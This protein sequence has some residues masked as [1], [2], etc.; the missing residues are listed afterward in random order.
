MSKQDW[1]SEIACAVVALVI[2]ALTLWVYEQQ[3]GAA[4]W[5]AQ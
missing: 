1:K 2:F 3:L 4:Q 5:I